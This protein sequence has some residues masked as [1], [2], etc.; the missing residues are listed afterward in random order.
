MNLTKTI[1]FVPDQKSIEPC[2][3]ESIRSYSELADFASS[4][5]A[6]ESLVGGE[7][8][9]SVSVNNLD[10][11]SDAIFLDRE[12]SSRQR[13]LDWT[14]DQRVR[15]LRPGPVKFISDKL[16]GQKLGE[17]LIEERIGS[18]GMARVYLAYDTT[19]KRHVA[20][21][22]I[23]NRKFVTQESQA[24][25]LKSEAISQAR[26]NHQNVVSIFH[27]GTHDHL[28]FLAMEYVD[29]ESLG[30]R[31]KKSSLTFAEIHKLSGQIVE[32]LI[33]AYHN[34][35]VHGDIKPANLL[36]DDNGTIKLSDFGLARHK[37]DDGYV[38]KALVG[39]PAYMAPELFDKEPIDE[40]SDLYSLGVTFF[41]M[42][43]GTLPYPVS[44]E[45]VKEVKQSLGLSE[46][47]FPGNWPESLPIA[48][49]KIL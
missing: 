16:V 11:F 43:F 29:G 26:L 22:V 36:I 14:G 34:G 19:L 33:E 47:E 24:N 25:L 1:D 39:T 44:G 5:H 48:W 45:T 15:E 49:K 8:F 41:Q 4:V 2:A 40:I 13:E 31:I 37:H 35:L 20:I 10:E 30:E 28:P 18:G 12:G 21:K 32:G 6:G 23:Q 17:F 9:P 46:I 3:P 27:V 7:K 42:T 38:Q